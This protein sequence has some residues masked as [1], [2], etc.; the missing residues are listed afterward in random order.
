MLV[1]TSPPITL[2]DKKQAECISVREY[3][4]STVFRGQTCFFKPFLKIVSIKWS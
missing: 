3:E 1:L 2:M 4:V